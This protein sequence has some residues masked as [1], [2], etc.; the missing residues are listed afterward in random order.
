M[1]STDFCLSTEGADV[2]LATSSDEKYPPENIIDGRPETFWT[3]TGMF[4][5][6]FIIC[7][8]K[9]V[10]ISKLTIQCYLVQTLRIEK[11]LSKDPVDFEHCI[12]KDF[13]LRHQVSCTLEPE[14]LLSSCLPGQPDLEYK[15]GELQTEEFSFPEFQATHLRFIILSAFDTFVSVHRVMTEGIAQ[16]V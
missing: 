8:H 10:I 2:I 12:E 7:F 4:P 3:T 13:N 1:K 14:D 5:Q 15:E 11:S 6:E 9:C 16:D